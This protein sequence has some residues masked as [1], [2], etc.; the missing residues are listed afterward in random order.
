[1]NK[2][3]I[4]IT[5]G[6][7]AYKTPDL[8]RKLLDTGF[9]I[10]VIMAKNATA[11]VS[12]L[13]LKTLLP[14][15]VFE[16]LIE[17][18]MQ[19]IRLA[20]WADIILIAPATANTIAKLNAG[21][22]DDLL[23]NVCLASA[24]PVFLAPAMNQAMWQHIATQNNIKR[25]MERGITFLGPDSGVQACGD[26]GPG[27]MLDPVDIVDFLSAISQ[28]PILQNI[29]LLITAG[30][31]REPIDPVRFITNKSSGKM[32]Y[33]LAQAASSLG[34]R[35]TLISGETNLARPHCQKFIKIQTTKEMQN[36]VENEITQQDIFISVAA[37]AD[38]TVANISPQKIKR[39]TD[40]LTL[41]LTPTIDILATICA[42]QTKPFTVSFAAE[43]ENVLENAK[44]K[45]LKK[46]VDII[47]VNDVSRSDIG[48]DSN[49]NAVSIISENKIFHLEK[50]SKHK[51]A[52]QL[53]KIINDAYCSKNSG[54]I[55]PSPNDFVG[56][57]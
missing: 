56:A 25:L 30:A 18:E 35:V 23:T 44:K 20:K 2:I 31:T 45:R 27:R 50:N 21:I 14:N 57:I 34:A 10:K 24:A 7:A 53:L 1:M 37:V 29:N 4:G 28:K 46:G 36:A 55:S 41:E 54:C 47:I 16:T 42:R 11:F 19:H 52:Q 49:D 5:G 9:E 12:L 39:G 26:I 48:F 33:A 17:P 22:A 32:G 43:T 6:I 40:T 8:I 15:N 51:I 38:Y 3:L 13:T